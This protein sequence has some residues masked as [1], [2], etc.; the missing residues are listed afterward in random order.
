MSINKLRCATILGFGVYASI[1]SPAVAQVRVFDLPA[2]EAVKSIPQFGEQSGLQI[3]APA[4]K[5]GNV[6]TPAITGQMDARAAL[7]L[8]IRDSGLVVA[9]NGNGVITLKPAPIRREQPMRFDARSGPSDQEVVQTAPVQ[10]PV[11]PEPNESSDR[12]VIVGSQIAGADTTGVVPVTVFGEEDIAALGAASGEDLYRSLPVAGDVSFNT[13]TL[14][15]GSQGAARGD[16]SSINLRGLGSSYT[17]LLLNG[18]RTVPYPITQ[19]RQESSYNAN[20]I[21]TFGLSRLEILRDGAAALYGADAVAGVVNNVLQT[22]YV[23]LKMQAQWGAAEGTHL[24]QIQFNVLAGTD[25]ADGRGN[26]TVFSNLSS[27]TA[28]LM[29]DQDFTASSDKRP[30]VADTTFAGNTSFDTRGTGSGWGG[31]QVRG[32]PGVITSNG[33]AITN[34]SGQ[35][36]IQPTTNAGCLYQLGNGICID[37]GVVTGAPD[38]NLRYDSAAAVPGITVTPSIRRMNIFSTI[39]YDIAD[40]LEFFGELGYYASKTESVSLPVGPLASTPVTIPANNYYNPFG[41]VGSPN[42]LP[43]LNIP[44]A[45]LP[46]TISSYLLTDVGGRPI[47]VMGYQHRAL[48]GLKGEMWDWDWESAIVYSDASAEDKSTNIQTSLWQQALARSTPDAYNPFNGANVSNPELWDTTPSLDLSSYLIDARRY[49]KASLGLWDLKISRPD[50]LALPAGDLGMAAGVEVRWETSEDDRDASGDFSTPYT[51]IVTGITYDSDTLGA[52]AAWDVRGNRTVHSAFVEFAIP[53][54]SP[55]MGIPLV[56]AIDVQLAG[57]YES[58]SD[59]G[60]VAKPKVAG[61]WDI[62]DG[63]RLRSS[64]Q[65]G[66]IAPALQQLAPVVRPT[67]QARLDDVL[68]EADLRAGR[69]ASW[70]ACSQRPQVQVLTAGNADLKPEESESLSYGLVLESTFLPE[71]LGFFTLTFDRWKIEQENKI[72]VLSAEN[73]LTL[74]YLMRVQGSSNPNVVRAAPT[75]A[76]IDFVA[77]TGLAPIGLVQSVITDYDNLDIRTIEGFDVGITYSLPSLPIGDISASVNYSE[78]LDF[79]QSPSPVQQEM[80]D[81]QAAGIINAGANIGGAASLLEDSG[82]PKVK[83]NANLTWKNG[84]IAAG[85]TGQYTGRVFQKAVLDPS[86]AAWEVE[87]QLSIGLWGEYTFAGENDDD[88]TLRIGVR[89]ITDEAPP[90]A[91]Q[92]YLGNLYQPYGRYFYGRIQKTF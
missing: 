43:G 12:V 75:Q 19:G 41:P 29:S 61:S 32:G 42:R 45:G 92:G 13:Q 88:T 76:D 70:G 9:H 50:V 3:I 10:Q 40:D 82:N 81:A 47:E 49:G 15:G 30:L 22:D 59:V 52:S 63:L 46:V 89:N 69:I 87:D 80:L 11:A 4:D 37:D 84:P 20:A 21:P 5:L 56:Q 16:V 23:G 54:V 51:D 68:C 8:L 24:Q 74:D 83:W 33:A 25:F 79:Y 28:L 44:D 58:Y 17:L 91:T 71:E 1:I 38:R 85:L 48:A 86:G 39:T 2:G 6:R 72:G 34:A 73:A 62:V 78:L 67:S 55:K 66:F 7:D 31:F 27:D 60:S 90:L 14:S 26:I 64:W 57:R 18:R 53:V 36:H 77:G 35:F 65:Q